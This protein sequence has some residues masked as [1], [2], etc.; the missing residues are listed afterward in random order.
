M[1]DSVLFDLSFR[2]EHWVF[3]DLEGFY[4]FSVSTVLPVISDLNA[5]LL[6]LL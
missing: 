3:L 1:C 2:G 5:L 4:V 6:L